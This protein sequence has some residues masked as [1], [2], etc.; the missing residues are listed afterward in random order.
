MHWAAQYMFGFGRLAM[1]HG[2]S[3]MNLRELP[4]CIQVDVIAK[5]CSPPSYAFVLGHVGRFQGRNV[6]D[7]THVRRA[8]K[9]DEAFHHTLDVLVQHLFLM[10]QEQTAGGKHER[11]R[12]ESLAV[13]SVQRWQRE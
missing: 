8:T 12:S 4:K 11:D 6:V 1:K 9:P 5:W 3:S 13:Q 2:Q 10:W 7:A